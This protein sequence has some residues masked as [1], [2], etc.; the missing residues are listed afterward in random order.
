MSPRAP[1]TGHAAVGDRLELRI[2][3]LVATGRGLARTPDG[4]VVFVEGAYPGDR[5]EAELLEVRADYAVARAARLL[6]AGLPRRASPC[7]AFAR[8][9]GCDWLDLE[10][11]LQLALARQIAEEALSRVLRDGPVELHGPVRSPLRLGYR[12]RAQ[13]KAAPDG[14]LGFHARG[15]RELVPVREC[16][17]LVPE[18]QRLLGPLAELAAEL[19][20]LTEVHLLAGTQAIAVGLR[21]RRRLAAEPQAVA[22][23]LAPYGVGSVVLDDATRRFAGSPT[24]GIRVGPYEHEGPVSSFFQGNAA[25]DEELVRRVV[26]AT[27][28]AAGAPAA[29]CG[30]EDEVLELYAGVGLFTLAL[31]ARSGRLVAV[32]LD[33]AACDALRGNLQRAGLEAS[34]LNLDAS[35]LAWRLRGHRPAAV[36]VDPPRTGLERG[37]RAALA[38]LKAPRVASLSC[39]LSTLARDLLALRPAYR[40]RRIELLDLFPQTSHLEALAILERADALEGG[41]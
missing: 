33:R 1:R 2:E 24:V 36:L 4:R 11:A 5:V 6:E 20:D 41:P 12:R 16:P 13:L 27:L 3:K 9:G 37:A 32:E 19:R 23:R 38:G 7:A 30:P 18:L 22:E 8:C 10:D 28:G 31:A 14:R 29:P 35:S 21:A 40:V 15:S 17:V 25:F 39:N 34:V 26:E